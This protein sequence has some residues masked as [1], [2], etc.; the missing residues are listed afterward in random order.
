MFTINMQ[1]FTLQSESEWRFVRSFL[2]EVD[3]KRRV[4]AGRNGGQRH[5][6]TWWAMQANGTRT[7]GGDGD[8]DDNTHMQTHAGRFTPPPLAAA[9]TVDKGKGKGKRAC[10]I[11]SATGNAR[12]VDCNDDDDDDADNDNDI[13][14]ADGDDEGD[15]ANTSV[16]DAAASAAASATASTAMSDTFANGFIVRYRFES[17]DTHA[18]TFILDGR[19][20]DAM[21]D[22]SIVH[23]RSARAQLV[24]HGD[25]KDASASHAAFSHMMAGPGCVINNDG[26]GGGGRCRAQT[27]NL[28]V[29]V[30]VAPATVTTTTSSTATAALEAAA[31]A[32]TGSVAGKK[33]AKSAPSYGDLLSSGAGHMSLTSVTSFS[34]NVRHVFDNAVFADLP[35]GRRRSR[36]F[37]HRT[38]SIKAPLKEGVVGLGKSAAGKAPTRLLQRGY[39]IGVLRQP[40]VFDLGFNIEQVDTTAAALPYFLRMRLTNTVGGASALVTFICVLCTLRTQTSR[41]ICNFTHYRMVS[42]QC[43]KMFGAPRT[44]MRQCRRRR[45]R[46]S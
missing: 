40:Y 42:K 4:R 9:A 6:Q 12:C 44:R 28:F 5:S 29:H 1:L 18:T 41:S 22:V 46:A 14:D 27:D 23:K 20:K 36:G 19:S 33:E 43:L 16:S 45:R 39:S 13:D 21:T 8:D 30:S 15:G 26:G 25:E 11:L 31:G 32:T 34:D 37:N 38:R 7:R 17:G 2:A 10:I 35:S 3:V 24:S